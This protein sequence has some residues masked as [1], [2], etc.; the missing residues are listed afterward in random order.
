MLM[1]VRAHPGSKRL[2]V[3]EKDGI[4]HVYLTAKPEGG[5]ANKQLL[6][7]L[8]ER[9]GPCRIVR[10]ARSRDKVVEV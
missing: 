8:K 10:G 5:R 1:D 9:Y 4:V 7:V 6:E 2:F 3:E